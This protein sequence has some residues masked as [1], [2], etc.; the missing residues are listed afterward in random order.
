MTRKYY[1]PNTLSS[2]SSSPPPSS[3]SAAASTP[4]PPQQSSTAASSSPITTTTHHLNN[5]KNKNNDR[6]NPNWYCHFNHSKSLPKK[7]EQ[8]LWMLITRL[9]TRFHGHVV[10]EK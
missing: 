1:K 3:S 9:I 7:I 4:P 5:I 6:D 2:S 10:R 8:T